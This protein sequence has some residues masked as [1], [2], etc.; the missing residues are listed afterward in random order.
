MCRKDFNM[1]AEHSDVV[2]LDS[3]VI[4]AGSA[5][6]RD[7]SKNAVGSSGE[8]V[9]SSSSGSGSSTQSGNECGDKKSVNETQHNSVIRFGSQSSNEQHWTESD[10]E[11]YMRRCRKDWADEE[12]E[13]LMEALRTLHE[14]ERSW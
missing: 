7:F 5:G 3:D 1:V 9:V 8:G 11:N 2:S 13:S 12:Q 14:L 4:D 10:L 6:V